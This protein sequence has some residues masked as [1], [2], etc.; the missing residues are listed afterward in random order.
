ML[1]F[2]EFQTLF[3]FRYRRYY[4]GS[5]KPYRA[6]RTYI[7]YSKRYN[8]TVTISNGME[9]DGATGAMDIISLAWWVHDQLCNTGVWDDGTRLTNWQ[10][11]R[12][13]SDILWFEGRYYRSVYWLFSTF[14]LG[15]GEARNNGMFKLKD[16]N[17]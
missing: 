10:C 8:K 1:P 15:G 5:E 6:L 4:N 11:S 7:F 16:I 2:N 3:N 14:A 12:V 17:D 13:L 9:A